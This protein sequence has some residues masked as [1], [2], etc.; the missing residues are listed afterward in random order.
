LAAAQDLVYPETKGIRPEN[1][2]ENARYFAEVGRLAVEDIDVRRL[3]TEVFH[4][5]KPL[6]ALFDEPVRNRIAA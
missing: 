4:L 1:M 6:S 2:Q 3:V 5:V